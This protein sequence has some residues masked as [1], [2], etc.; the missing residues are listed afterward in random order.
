WPDT[1]RL[2]DFVRL[3]RSPLPKLRRVELP[4]G[5]P[6][7]GILPRYLLREF[8]NL[9]NGYYSRRISTGYARAFD[10]VMLGTL[11]RARRRMVQRLAHLRSVL[12][13]GC[14]AGQL[15]GALERAGVPDVWG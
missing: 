5:L 15:A 12:D 1:H 2:R 8:H 7:A 9:P 4:P 3:A 6:G 14:G 10:V 11:R 13:V